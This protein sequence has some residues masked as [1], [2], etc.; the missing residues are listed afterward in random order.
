MATFII[1]A[2]LAGS[3]AGAFALQK[4][5]LEALFRMMAPQDRR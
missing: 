1:G 5:V 3:M 4:A 2:T